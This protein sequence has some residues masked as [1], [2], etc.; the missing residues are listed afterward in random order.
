M[1]EAPAEGLHMILSSRLV[2]AL[3]AAVAT[4]MVGAP[5]VLAQ[6]HPSTV[7]PSAIRHIQTITPSSGPAG[8]SVSVSTLNLPIEAKVHVGVGA[9][10][11][12]FEA[13]AE[14]QQGRWGEIAVRVQVPATTSWDRPIVFIAFNA[15]FAPIGLSDPFHVTDQQGRVRRTGQVTDEAESCLTFRD[16]DGYLYALS[17]DVGDLRPGYEVRIDGVYFDTGECIDG[18]TIGVSAIAR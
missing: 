8:T 7:A 11:A 13:L 18:P 15:V 10:Q 1:S 12:G 6:G 14:A 3:A 17:G 16:Q 5:T 4:T 2:A 9:M